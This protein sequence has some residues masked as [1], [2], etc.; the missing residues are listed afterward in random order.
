MATPEAGATEKILDARIKLKYDTWNN[1]NTT[2]AKALILEKGEL[3]TVYVPTNANSGETQSEPAF[4]I[5]IGDGATKFEN[6]PW[7]Q[8]PAADVHKWAKAATK[9]SYAADEI[10]GLGAMAKAD[11]ASGATTLATVDSIIMNPVTVAGNATV[12]STATEA[13]LTKENY[14]PAGTVSAPTVNLTFTEKTFATGLTGGKVASFTEGAFTPASFQG[15]FYTAG[16]AATWTGSSYTAPTLGSATTGK[17][18]LEG[19]MVEVG[20]GDEAETLIFSAAGTANAVTAQGAFNA[21]NVN[22]GTFNGGKATVIDVTK[23]SGGSKAKDT[24]TANV[25][26]GVSTGTVNEVTAATATAPEFTGTLA[27][28]ALVTGASYDKADTAA[29]F[30]VNVTPTVKEIKKTA[31]NIILYV[32]PVSKKISGEGSN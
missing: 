24:F 31:K 28:D 20:T 21:G 19:T 2:N 8:A 15:G 13:T 5:K 25:L 12:T 16:S 9:P 11:S 32:S 29:A 26:Q 22:F 18:A 10:T 3:A 7:I 1:W 6:L 23:F 14:T 27:K 17:F 4:L 30:S